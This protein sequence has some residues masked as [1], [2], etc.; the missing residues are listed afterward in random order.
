MKVII[1]VYHCNHTMNIHKEVKDID[2]AYNIMEKV[3][4]RYSCNVKLY[5]IQ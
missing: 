1:V 3:K 5:V 4:H 2:E